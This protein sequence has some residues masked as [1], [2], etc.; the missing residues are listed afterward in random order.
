MI[1]YPTIVI[2]TK[3]LRNV[4]DQHNEHLPYFVTQTG[5]GYN[6]TAIIA[7]S[8]KNS[9][10]SFIHSFIQHHSTTKHSTNLYTHAVK[11]NFEESVQY[12]VRGF[13]FASLTL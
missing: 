6:I 10:I 9:I 5:N 11:L 13:Q 3:S 2:S 4:F 1:V 8:Y 12:S 7:A